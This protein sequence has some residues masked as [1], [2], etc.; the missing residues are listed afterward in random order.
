MNSDFL[1][2]FY[3]CIQTGNFTKAAKRLSITQSALS[4]R[5]KNLEEDL[6]TTLLIR[7][8]AGLKLT[9]S[10][11]V[12]LRYCKKKLQAE[13]ELMTE[14]KPGRDAKKQSPLSGLIR[15]GGYSSVNRSKILPA[16]SPLLK[17]YSELS[18]RMVT[19]EVHELRPLLQS[20]EIDF[21]ILDHEFKKDGV[22]S[23]KIGTEKNVLV[24]KR[25]Y[26]GAD[27][28]LDHDEDDTTTLNYLKKKS[29]AG[30]ERRY[31]DDIDGV[32]DGVILGL[33]RAVVPLHLIETIKNIEIVDEERFVKNEIYL[34]YYEQSFYSRLH[35]AVVS[36]ISCV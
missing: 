24:Q 10:G 33:G 20:G 35:E 31:L 4:Q 16:L 6:A 32:I 3:T 13:S 26:A 34:H 23:V 25:G 5:I 15:I 19:R 9:E 12:L 14:L 28:F 27:I 1:D 29:S 22:V 18:I 36:A 8:R 2:A 21:M 11:E 7:D 17:A 30:I